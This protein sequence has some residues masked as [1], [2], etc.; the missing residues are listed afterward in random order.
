[1]KKKNTIL[2]ILLFFVSFFTFSQSA[3]VGNKKVQNERANTLYQYFTDAQFAL[4]KG[5][6]ND[7][8]NILLALDKIIPD[9]SNVL[10]KIGSTYVNYPIYPNDNAMGIPYLEKSLKNISIDYEG[11]Y[12]DTTAP[13]HAYYYLAKGYLTANRINDAC[14]TNKKFY[15]YAEQY[16]GPAYYSEIKKEDIMTRAEKQKGE[17]NTA[18]KLTANP[19][20]VKLTKL[21]TTVNASFNEFNAFIAPDNKLY[22]TSRSIFDA[23]NLSNFGDSLIENIFYVNYDKETKNCSQ[24]VN[25]FPD[26][27]GSCSIVG[28]S[29]DGNTMLIYKNDV[30]NGDLFFSKL[31]NNTWSIP[32]SF[33]SSINGSKTCESHASLSPDGKTLYF[34]SERKG[35]YGGFDLY[36]S[37]L[38]AAG[39]WSKPDNMGEGINTEF[40]EVAPVISNDGNTLFYSSNGLETM[41]D[42]DIFKT[43]PEGRNKWSAPVNIGYPLNTTDDNIILSTSVDGK[44]SFLSSRTAKNGIGDLDIYEVSY[45]KTPP[46]VTLL[47]KV[48]D[49]ETKLPLHAKILILSSENKD[50]LN[51]IMND[52][53][54]GLFN[55]IVN[56]KG[57]NIQLLVSA[58]NYEPYSREINPLIN[59]IDNSITLDDIELVPIKVVIGDDKKDASGKVINKDGTITDNNKQDG[60][61]QDPQDE[62]IIQLKNIYYD[63]DKSWLRPESKTELQRLL[64]FMNNHPKLKIQIS[65]HADSVGT[66]VY[67]NAL[68]IRRSKAVVEFLVKNGISSERLTYY[69]YGKKSPAATNTTEEGRQLNRRSEFKILKK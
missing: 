34:S 62:E 48:K 21:G 57:K 29:A 8:I 1:M 61:K 28:L 44:V 23:T 63:F 38:N 32:V 4:D 37:T 39:Q 60:L 3:T 65:S 27:K 24:A 6:Y 68:S 15:N 10:Y 31:E 16:W 36:Y 2:F 59:N 54:T 66:D 33:G 52:D 40:D 49:A 12:L 56:C 7:A 35:G 13:I 20:N 5:R 67:N 47:G 53:K 14:E 46:P 55:T 9:N 50:T 45:Y 25:V 64:K 30:G 18:V 58:P 26:Q 19:L 11:Q 17:C 69:G 43:S 41:G 51:D 42:F 22:F